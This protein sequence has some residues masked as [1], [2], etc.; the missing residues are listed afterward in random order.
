MVLRAHEPK[1]GPQRQ[2]AL[3][4][5]FCQ[6]TEQQALNVNKSP[7][8]SSTFEGSSNNKQVYNISIHLYR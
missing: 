8:Y 3:L 1:R 4:M 5:L 2:G 7:D 6:M